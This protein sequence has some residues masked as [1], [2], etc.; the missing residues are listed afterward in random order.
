MSTGPDLRINGSMTARLPHN[1]HVSVPGVDARML[2][3]RKSSSVANILVIREHPTDP[4]E[5]N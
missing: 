4:R 5:S 3:A 1:L 2:G